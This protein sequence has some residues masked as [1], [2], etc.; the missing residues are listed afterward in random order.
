VNESH[1]RFQDW[2][3]AGA[4]GEPHR[5]LAVHA[6]VCPACRQSILALDLL[7]MADPG[8]ARQPALQPVVERGALGRGARLAGLATAG[9]FAAVVVGVGASQLSNLSRGGSLALTSPTPNQQVFGG[10]ATAQPTAGVGSA[11]PGETLTPLDSPAVSSEPAGA[12]PAPGSTARPTIRPGATPGPT[13][14]PTAVPT[15]GASGTTAPTPTEVPTAPP[16]PVATPEPTVE[17]TPAPTPTPTVPD[18]PALTA[19]PAGTGEVLLSWTTPSDG[20]DAITGYQLFYSGG[21]PVSGGSVSFGTNSFTDT[22]L[23]P[24]A[25]YSYYVVAINSVGP[26]LPSNTATANAGL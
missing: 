3:I 4:E 26:S 15:P 6:W 22:G 18:A 25:P 17:P 1:Q 20:G 19:T 12:T 21:T 9:L 14:V 2:L 11:A 7:A 8:R 24:D 23:T 13:G 5:D 10:T 16:T